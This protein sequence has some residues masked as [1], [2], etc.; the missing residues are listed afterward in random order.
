MMAKLNK[1]MNFTLPDREP[2][3]E[4][5]T[6]KKF[7]YL[8]HLLNNP[9]EADLRSLGKWQASELISQAKDAIAD[10]QEIVNNEGDQPFTI[11][12]KTVF[13]VFV[14]FVV[15]VGIFSD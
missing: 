13:I 2:E 11:S 1:N 8:T 15:L 5:I 7:A 3:E 12:L 14:V 6:E 10:N 9:D 4:D